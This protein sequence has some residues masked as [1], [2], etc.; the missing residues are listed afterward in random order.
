MAILDNHKIL[1]SQVNFFVIDLIQYLKSYNLIEYLAII[2]TTQIVVLNIKKAP[3]LEGAFG[4]M[5]W[6]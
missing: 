1:K 5:S 3:S 4:I 6:R 2:H